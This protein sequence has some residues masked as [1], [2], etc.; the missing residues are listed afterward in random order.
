MIICCVMFTCCGV[1]IKGP[2][3]TVRIL[4]GIPLLVERPPP[5]LRRRNTG[6]YNRGQ[7]CWDDRPF[8]PPPQFN[9]E[10]SSFRSG[11]ATQRCAGGGGGIISS[12]YM[13]SSV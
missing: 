9:V 8:P 1:P 2:R 4:R 13:N 10:I 12:S 6:T 3:I 5:T 7:N 11:E